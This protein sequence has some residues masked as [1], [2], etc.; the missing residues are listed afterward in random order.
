MYAKERRETPRATPEQ[1]KRLFKIAID[2]SLSLNVI[3]ML[4]SIAG[5]DCP[6]A[7][8]YLTFCINRKRHA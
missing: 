7:E 5:Y 2:A 4:N 1:L 6:S 3:N 8:R